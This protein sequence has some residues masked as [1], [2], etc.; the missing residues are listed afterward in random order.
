SMYPGFVERAK[1]VTRLVSDWRTTFVVVSTLEAA[2]VREAEYFARELAARE[3]GLGAIVLNK[4]L[5]TFFRDRDAAQLAGQ[6]RGGAGPVAEQLSRSLGVDADLTSSVLA[7]VAESFSN[8]GVVARREAEQQAEL[9]TRSEVLVT[10]PFFDA[11]IVDME[12]LLRVG[13][14]MWS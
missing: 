11:D 6:L 9:A 4:V 3:L 5:P 8:F 2:P 12:G 13:S 10:V 14:M 1:A 7:E